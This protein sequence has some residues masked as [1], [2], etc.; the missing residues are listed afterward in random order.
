MLVP[1][2]AKKY[3]GSVRE[4]FGF[5]RHIVVWR[6]YETAQGRERP[7]DERDTLV[8]TPPPH[9][10]ERGMSRH[11]HTETVTQKWTYTNTHEP[12]PHPSPNTHTDLRHGVRSIF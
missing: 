9:S 5:Q 2:V 10:W 6:I 3:L 1:C 4:T 11:T 12:S 8:H 7:T